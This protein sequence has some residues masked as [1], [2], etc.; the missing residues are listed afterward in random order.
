MAPEVI[1]KI[2]YGKPA[3]IWSIGCCVI[4]M[5]TSKPP[6]S[7]FGKDAKVIMDVIKNS[8]NPPRYPESISKECK[9]FLDYCF[10]MDQSKRA[11]ATELLY[12]PFVLSK[13]LIHLIPFNVL[14][15]SEKSK[16]IVGK[17]RS[18]KDNAKSD[19]FQKL[20]MEFNCLSKWGSKLGRTVPDLWRIVL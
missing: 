17:F 18:C 19:N 5:L 12:H 3:D 6:W 7:E 13:H 10:E 16:G 1:R 9:D 2:G 11:T 4:E 8:Q 14:F 20:F 15:Y